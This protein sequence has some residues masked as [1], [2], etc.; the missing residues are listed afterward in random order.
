MA[1]EASAERS[2]PSESKPGKSGGR[3]I[4]TIIALV[5][6]LAIIVAAVLLFLQYGP[7]IEDFAP[8]E[9]PA[10]EPLEEPLTYDQAQ[11][12]VL[13]KVL[14]KDETESIV[15]MCKEPLISGDV[16]VPQ[17]GEDT[18]EKAIG[19]NTYF[20]FID[21]DP[22]AMWSH[23]ARYVYI[24]ADTGV[25]TTVDATWPPLVNGKT[26]DELVDEGDCTLEHTT[27]A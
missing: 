18:T 1:E 25:I 27:V 16:V 13:T 4:G 10:A 15:S 21:D 6:V 5:V 26:L 12:Q 24:D 23:D 9:E 2:A 7:T 11:Q 8:V 14:D 17:G 19:G 22:R 20:A 3:G